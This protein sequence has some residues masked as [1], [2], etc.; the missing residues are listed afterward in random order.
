VFGTAVYAAGSTGGSGCP[1]DFG[2]LVATMYQ[3][4]NTAVD[5][6]AAE[7]AALGGHGVVAVQV[8]R[9]PFTLGGQEFTA[10]GTAV[11]AA[12]ARTG[13]RQPFTSG[14]S[15]QDFARLVRAGWVPAGLALGIAMG[16]WHDDRATVRQGRPWS[17]NAEMDGW[18]ALVNQARRDAR[19][20]LE[21]DVRRL[22]AEGVVIAGMRLHARARDCPVAAGRRDHIV[23]V[24]LTGTAIASFSPAGRR[25]TGPAQA[26]MRLNR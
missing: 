9:G 7:C 26:V 13:P 6:M 19:S 18:T 14:L 21:D 1:G 11:R 24:T 4:R 17:A 8:T 12:C 5:R 3:A 22:G 25:P 10:I 15:G 23:E 16:S 20:R 2:S